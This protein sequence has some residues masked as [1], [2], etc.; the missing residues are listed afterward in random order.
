[1]LIGNAKIYLSLLTKSSRKK[2]VAARVL[3]WWVDFEYSLLEH[4]DF[5]QKFLYPNISVY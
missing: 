4:F 1:M 3:G 5:L 2:M